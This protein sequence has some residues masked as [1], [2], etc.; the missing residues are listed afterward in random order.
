MREHAAVRVA[1]AR[2]EN[3]NASPG[4]EITAGGR[5]IRL[6]EAAGM[7]AR[8]A[9]RGLDQFLSTT[10]IA[11]ESCGLGCRGRLW[12]EDTSPHIESVGG[13]IS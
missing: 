4:D 2:A 1:A 13:T 10:S 9:A 8:A 3:A 12:T 11:F 7:H 6:V 5:R